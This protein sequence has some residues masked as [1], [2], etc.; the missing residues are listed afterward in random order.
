MEVSV[1]FHGSMAARWF[2]GAAVESLPVRAKPSTRR[3]AATREVHRKIDFSFC[4][5]P[6]VDF[7]F[8]A[9]DVELGAVVAD[10]GAGVATE[11][12]LTTLAGPAAIE[13]ATPTSAR[14]S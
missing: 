12:L 4:H 10:G 6:P 13:G 14:V 9:A 5:G 8:G 3:T 7:F 2:R 1:V 11:A